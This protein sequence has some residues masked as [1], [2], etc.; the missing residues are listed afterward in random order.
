MTGGGGKWSLERLQVHSDDRGQL[1]AFESG[2]DV[3]FPIRRV[4]FLY[5]VPGGEQ[6][7]FH[8]HRTLEVIAVA[9]S[10][11][12]TVVLDDGAHR[13][14]LRLDAP[15]TGLFIHPMVWHEMRD[16][17]QDCV[18]L[19]LA[20]D[21]YDEADYIRDYDAFRGSAGEA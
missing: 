5:G 21:L 20:S 4:F 1:V 12:C 13:E 7:G 8:A 2:K 9:V 14:E 17:S 15:D 18:L 10:G 19:V 11:S 6:R 16:F 3:P